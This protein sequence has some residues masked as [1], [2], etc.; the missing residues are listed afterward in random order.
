[1]SDGNGCG[2]RQRSEPG[3]RSLGHCSAISS[4][5]LPHHGTGTFPLTPYWFPACPQSSSTLAISFVLFESCQAKAFK[6]SYVHGH[7][8]SPPSTRVR[9]LRLGIRQTDEAVLAVS[10][11]NQGRASSQ[12]H[13]G[14]TARMK[15]Q[16]GDVS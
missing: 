11:R 12:R 14:L 9:V 16:T 1:M 8:H 2:L 5:N 3:G 6:L 13:E 4:P 15:R 10:S 7:H